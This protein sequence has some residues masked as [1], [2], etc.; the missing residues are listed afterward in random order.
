MKQIYN[1]TVDLKIGT[2]EGLKYLREQKAILIDL[3][4]KDETIPEIMEG[5]LTF[6]D[7][8]QDSL[9]YKNG[10]PEN[11]VFGNIERTQ[12]NEN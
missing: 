2:N 1:T 4:E 12:E 6:I 3:L 7:H 10:V 5:L 11:A 8:I 9:V